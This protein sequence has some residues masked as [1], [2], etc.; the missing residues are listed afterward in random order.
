[1]K[2]YVN[3][4][5]QNFFESIHRTPV[6]TAGESQEILSN[7]AGEIMEGVLCYCTGTELRN[8]A[9]W[10]D[11]LLEEEKTAMIQDDL[12][13]FWLFKSHLSNSKILSAVRKNA[14]QGHCL[15][16]F[17]N[18]SRHHSRKSWRKAEGKRILCLGW[19]GRQNLEILVSPQRYFL[20][21]LAN[22]SSRE[23]WSHSVL[24]KDLLADS[25]ICGCVKSL[26]KTLR[27]YLWLQKLH[28]YG[29]VHLSW[30]FFQTL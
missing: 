22:T 13:H 18:S 9:S 15:L 20:P 27:I 2:Y 7:S 23:I 12:L 29:K 4:C 10:T 30:T 16:L 11:V 8:W 1:M 28:P 24:N 25:R 21:A 5:K 3:S 14:H 17:P 19:K 26:T 6:Y